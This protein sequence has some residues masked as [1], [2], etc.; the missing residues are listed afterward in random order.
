L[1]SPVARRSATAA[2]AL[3]LVAG[4]V[5]GARAQVSPGPLSKAH[6]ELDGNLGCARCHGKGEGEMDR[7]CL[8][9]HEEIASLVARRTGFHGR[10]GRKDC[11]R[12]HPDHGGRDFEMIAWPG[13]SPEAFDHARAG[14]PLAGKHAAVECRV[15]H[16]S[17]HVSEEMMP[18][19]RNRSRDTPWVGLDTGCR[20]CHEDVHR[21]SLGSDCA[22]CHDERGWRPAHGFDHAQTAFALTGKHATVACASCHEAAHLKLAKDSKGRAVPL[23]KPLPHD[24]C[25][26]CHADPHKGSFGAACSRCHV[27]QGFDRIEATRFDHDRTRYPLRG[28]HARVKCATCHDEKTAWG[29]KPPFAAC[30]GCHRDAHGG[31]TTVAGKATDCAA[32]HGVDAF[33]PSTFTVA[34]HAKTRYPLEGAHARVACRDCHGRKPPGTAAQVSAALGSAGV[35][36]HP[37]SGRCVECHHDPHEGRFAPGGERARAEDCVACHTMAAFRPSRVDATMHDRAR[38][39]LE[40]AHRAVPCFACHPEMTEQARASSAR[41]GAAAMLLRIEKRACHDCHETPHGVQFDARRDG[42]ACDLCHG[43]DGFVP[44]TRFDHARVKN[45]KLDGAHARVPCE[46]CHP[47]V[48]SGGKRM[49]LYRPLSARCESCHADGDVLEN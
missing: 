36:L 49:T 16:A 34:Q 26:V 12:C 38:F 8:A 7:R 43:L 2:I 24:E 11:A 25:G 39:A 28:A 27:T 45:F 32:C 29:K 22:R 18:L 17:K 4:G 3:A 19:L 10:E 31:Q 48:T 9:C 44:A 5:I 37:A 21:G 1:A 6:A 41:G 46:K 20:G 23:Y 14:W 40:G 33:A 15:C 42:G 35:W 13:K 30:G 47:R